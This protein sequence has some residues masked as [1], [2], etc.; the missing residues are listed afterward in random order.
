MWPLLGWQCENTKFIFKCKY[1][2]CHMCN[3]VLV[4][5]VLKLTLLLFFFFFYMQCLNY[6]ISLLRWK[7]LSDISMAFVA[8]RLHYFMLNFHQEKSWTFELPAGELAFWFHFSSWRCVCV[9][10]MEASKKY[11]QIIFRELLY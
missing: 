6:I 3:T 11:V 4:Q 1:A 2:F 8:F 10:A 5:S 9:Y 7:L